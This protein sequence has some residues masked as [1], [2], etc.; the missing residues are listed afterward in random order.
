MELRNELTGVSHFPHLLHAYLNYYLLLA[1]HNFELKSSC[2]VPY[3][4]DMVIVF[5][6]RFRGSFR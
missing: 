3:V 1:L 4:R 6:S 5:E 2:L